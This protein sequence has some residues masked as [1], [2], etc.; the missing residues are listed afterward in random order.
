MAE[1]I[2]VEVVYAESGRQLFRR[3]ELPFGSTVM[4][5]VEASGIAG[6]VEGLQIDPARLG[7]FSRKVQPDDV[8]SDGDRVEIYRPLTLDPKEARRKRA[9]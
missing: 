9:G 6:M 1:R 3:V 7:V 2:V 4:Q 5:A 8:L